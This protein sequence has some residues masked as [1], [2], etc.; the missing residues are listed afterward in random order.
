VA[1]ILVLL[2]TA[3]K[4]KRKFF[5]S[6]LFLRYAYPFQ[7]SFRFLKKGYGIFGI[8]DSIKK[9]A[10]KNNDNSWFLLP[11]NKKP[12]SMK[13]LELL[14]IYRISSG[15]ASPKKETLLLIPYRWKSHGLWLMIIWRSQF[16]RCTPE[17]SGGFICDCFQ[18]RWLEMNIKKMRTVDYA[19]P[20]LAY[21]YSLDLPV[22]QTT[23]SD[24]D[25]S[26]ISNWFN[27][28][29][30]NGLDSWGTLRK[31]RA[32]IPSPISGTDATKLTIV[33]TTQQMAI[34]PGDAYGTC[35]DEKT[36]WFWN[37]TSEEEWPRWKNFHWWKLHNN[38]RPIN[39]ATDHGLFAPAS[40]IHLVY[41]YCR[42]IIEVKPEKIQNR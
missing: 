36:I 37:A 27:D 29:P 20:E 38:L 3:K 1:K 32:N 39:L 34:P 21:T 26:M 9:S 4:D 15:L 31:K 11:L 10:S 25:L 18:P 6:K 2:G 23:R 14:L 33:Y 7:D 35:I 17:C 41:Q 22:D 16:N 24:K 40:E 19:T 13:K 30:F 28:L 5:P 8:S 12:I 42:W